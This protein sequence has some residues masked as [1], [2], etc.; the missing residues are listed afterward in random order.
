MSTTTMTIVAVTTSLSEDSTTLKLTDRILASATSAGESVGI[1][2]N[3]EVINIR[4]LATAL[5]DMTLTG[6]RSEALEAAFAAVVEADAVVSVAPVYKVAP[7]GLHT[8]F[9]QLIDEKA[10]ARTPVLI[11]STGGTPR[12]S[13]AGEAVL[14]PMLAYLKGVVVPT[15]V[16]AATDDWGSSEG[17]RALSARIRQAAEEVVSL[18]AT[19]IGAGKG[20]L[21]EVADPE[22]SDAQ[23]ASGEGAGRARGAGQDGRDGRGGG[24][25][26]EFDPANVTPFAQLLE[27]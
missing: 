19:L 11:A 14:R 27:G 13:L 23:F 15:T 7:V 3:T 2:V 22:T 6:F 16:F 4:D 18:T 21:A 5:S 17:G 8:L 1:E 24:I 20:D 10:L 12:H 26:D 9:W 25:V